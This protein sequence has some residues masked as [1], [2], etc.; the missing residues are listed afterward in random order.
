MAF[1][2]AVI[3]RQ[4]DGARAA[5]DAGAEVNAFLELHAHSTALHQAAL[6][7]D[8]PMVELLLS[9]G[10]RTDIRDRVHDG[11]PL[12]WATFDGRPRAVTALLQGAAT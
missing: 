11:T 10:A 9:R 4:V 2:L 5:L 3:N 6:E 12:Q 8:V 1:T 7:D